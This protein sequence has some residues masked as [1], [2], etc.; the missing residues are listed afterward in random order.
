MNQIKPYPLWIGHGRD[1][2]DFRGLFDRD[3]RAVVQ[4]AAEEPAIAAPRELI[5]YRF[6]LVDGVG[7]GLELL[8][9][10]I[11]A[12]ASLIEQRI[13]TLV[14]CGAGMSRSPAIVAAALSRLGVG[15]LEEC[16]KNV[17]ELHPADVVPGLWEDIHRCAV[18][19][20]GPRSTPTAEVP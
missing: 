12:V 20:A 10:A 1:A 15:G 8:R 16:L 2:Q 17:I 9:L 11:A 14:C 19:G 7:N 4:L 6:P 5:L 3:I 18:D 13:S